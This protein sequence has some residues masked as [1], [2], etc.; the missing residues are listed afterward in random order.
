MLPTHPAYAVGSRVGRV[1][2]RPRGPWLARNTWLPINPLRTTGT[3]GKE[4][5]EIRSHCKRQVHRFLD[6][7][8]AITLK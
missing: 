3:L 4:A 1:S 7:D 6:G 5:V 8:G 2:G